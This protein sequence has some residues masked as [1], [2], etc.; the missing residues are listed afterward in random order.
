MCNYIPCHARDHNKIYIIFSFGHY[1]FS[2]LY[3]STVSIMP[4]HELHTGKIVRKYC[5][6]ILA[7][8]PSVD[9]VLF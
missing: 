1:I 5:E 8:F 9:V 7:I 6:K 2:G 3:V 4:C